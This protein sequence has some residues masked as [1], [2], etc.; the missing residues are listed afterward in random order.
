MTNGMMFGERRVRRS[1][2]NMSQ[3]SGEVAMRIEHLCN[4]ARN[5]RLSLEQRWRLDYDFYRLDDFTWRKVV[6]D[7]ISPKA[8]TYTS[9][10]PRTL[11]NVVISLLVEALVTYR[12]PTVDQPQPVREAGRAREQLFHHFLEATDQNMADMVNVPLR[13]QL[14]FYMAIRGFVAAMHTLYRDYEGRTQVMIEPWDP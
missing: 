1:P 3:R 10:E 4:T 11:A 9:N 12:S 6:Q 14:C 7:R 13:D 2:L 5:N 8:A